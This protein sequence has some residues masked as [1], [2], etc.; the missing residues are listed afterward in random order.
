MVSAHFVPGL[1]TYLSKVPKRT[2]GPTKAYPPH[3]HLNYYGQSHLK[4]TLLPKS[5]IMPNSLKKK[6]Y[7]GTHCVDRAFCRTRL[8][9]VE[10]IKLY[11]SFAE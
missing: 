2:E 7:E 9:S 6:P 8:Q 5:P 3:E 11:V 10:S 1:R 4:I